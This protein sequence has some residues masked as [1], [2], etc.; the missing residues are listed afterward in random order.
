MRYARV[1]GGKAVD[2][3][4]HAPDG[5]FTPDVAAQFVVVPDTVVDGSA[6]DRGAWSAPAVPE[7]RAPQPIYADIPVMDL[8]LRLTS[9]ER[10]TLRGSV[11]PAALDYMLILGDPRLVTVNTGS[12][13]VKDFLSYLTANGVIAAGRADQIT[14]AVNG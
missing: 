11:D 8:L 5:R 12:A 9:A 10:V 4:E 1:I 3:S 14:G 7:A 6:L 13:L 2:V